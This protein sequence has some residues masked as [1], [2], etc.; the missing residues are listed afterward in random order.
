MSELA[1]LERD[2][3]RLTNQ[4]AALHQRR[5]DILAAQLR[6]AE[7]AAGIAPAGGVAAPKK[8]GPAKKKGGKRRG[9][10]PGSGAAKK[11]AGRPGRPPGKA[12][13]KKAAA[14]K[15][16]G[17]RKRQDSAVIE[18][19][20]YDEVKAAGSAGISCKDVADKT[21]LKYQTV[22]KKLKELKGIKKTGTLKKARYSMK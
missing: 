9:R 3:S 22:A 19:K 6:D 10:P 18:S 13:S 14:K 16:G 2:I 11:K 5:V 7:E 12:P 17:R 15:K 4:L 1:Q 20:I 21:G 8:K